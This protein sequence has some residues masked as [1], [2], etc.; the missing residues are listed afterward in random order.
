MCLRLSNQLEIVCIV[1]RFPKPRD[2][3]T[4]IIWPGLHTRK[5]LDLSMF[6][7][8]A[9]DLEIEPTDMD[10]KSWKTNEMYI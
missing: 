3:P 7:D 4:S 5:R 8:L 2:R 1:G 9:G 6:Y 10:S